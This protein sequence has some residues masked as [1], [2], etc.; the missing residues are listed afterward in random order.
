MPMQPKPLS[1]KIYEKAKELEIHAIN[2]EFYRGYGEGN[3]EVICDRK[4]KNVPMTYKEIGEFNAEIEDW[5]WS[6]YE[7]EGERDGVDYGDGILYDLAKNEVTASEWYTV[8]EE[9]P[10]ETTELQV[11]DD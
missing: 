11:V 4:E 3:L 1:R 10:A 6:V 2:L 9:P 8:Q 7:Y 5:A